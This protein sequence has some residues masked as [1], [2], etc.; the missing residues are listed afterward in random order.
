MSDWPLLSLVIF[1]P[2]AGAGF[3]LTIRGEDEVVAQNAKSVAL[4]SSRS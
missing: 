3:I 2:L 1:L 4:W